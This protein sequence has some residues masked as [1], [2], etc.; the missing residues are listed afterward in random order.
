MDMRD[1]IAVDTETFYDKKHYSVSDLGNWGY[2]HDPRFD[3]YMVTVAHRDWSYAGPPAQAPWERMSQYPIWLSHNKGFDHHVIERCH[4]LGLAPGY[5]Y[6]KEW[7][8]TAN[9]S[10]YLLA[11][12]YLAGAAQHLL[13]RTLDKGVRDD[14][15][16]VR[17]EDASEELKTRLIEYAKID[18]SVLL[19]L[20][21]RHS[22]RWPQHERE[23]SELTYE[24]GD[25]GVLLN[26]EAIDKALEELKIIKWKAEQRIPWVASPTVD[27]PKAGPLSRKGLFRECAK[28][29]IAPPPTL[30]KDDTRADDWL[31]EH[32]GKVDWVLAVRTWRR[33]NTLESRLQ[34]MKDR[35]RPDNG[36]MPYSLF[37][38]GAQATGR[39]AG[40]GGVNMQ[41]LVRAP[42]F[43]TERGDIITDGLAHTKLF[44]QWKNAGRVNPEGVRHTVDVRSMIVAP[45][46][47]MLLIADLAQIEARAVLWFCRDW[48]AL[49]RV[50]AGESV[51]ET[52]ARTTM[53]WTGG[54]LKV[55]DA[56]KYAL[57]KARVLALGFNAGSV[58]FAEMAKMYIPDVEM[59]MEIFGRHVDSLMVDEYIDTSRRWLKDAKLT[60]WDDWWRALTPDRKTIQVNSHFQVMDF[61]RTNPLLCDKQTGLWAKLQNLLVQACAS[62]DRELEIMLPSGRALRYSSL[63]KGPG[64]IVGRQADGRN[65]T[66]LYGGKVL[67]NMAQAFSRDIFSL[68]ELRAKKRGLPLIMQTHDELVAEVG[69]NFDGS[70][71]DALMTERHPGALT[72]PLGVEWEMVN[73][74]KK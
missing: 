51:Y 2:T 38:F 10:A 72:L 44:K 19:D 73:E 5:A 36:R 21:E 43:L 20:W 71:M 52:H 23:L 22:E 12:R 41:N 16:G 65:F 28:L 55:E 67:E 70:I 46:G 74:Y 31:E 64:G 56:P 4:E 26:V 60:E 14:M 63:R 32:A 35:V 59:Y 7:H 66:G 13:D 48:A 3:C 53:G 57:A 33:V 9:M 68:C 42:W 27:L 29:G 62:P 58:R 8:C 34:T 11:P 47:K 24:M 15:N 40:A 50:E 45:P 69:K 6:P 17:W 54:E 18:A 37:Y 25:R 39:W 1:V 61:R 49:K 30:K